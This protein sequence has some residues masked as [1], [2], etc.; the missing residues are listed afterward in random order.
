MTGVAIIPAR[1]GSSRIPRKN[2]VEFRGR[3]MLH[4]PI[5]A[6]RQSGLFSA[7]YV[8]T[9]DKSIKTIAINCGAR[10]I[11]RPAHLALDEVGTQKVMQQAVK[12]LHLR[13]QTEVCCIYAAT[14]LLTAN[15]LRKA[16]ALLNERTAYVVAVADAPDL[17]DIGWL[18][19]GRAQFFTENTP[20]WGP[21]TRSY[22]V[23]LGRAIDINTPEDLMKAEAAYDVIHRRAA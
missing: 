9:E 16:H 5:E 1:G 17:K 18:Y 21:Y 7:I 11:S 23:E 10:V 4:Y 3:P 13:P 14:P 6:A 15:D 12:A 2:V 8:S 19:Y 20:L 22:P